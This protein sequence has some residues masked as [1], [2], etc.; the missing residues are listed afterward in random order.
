MRQWRIGK[1][2]F[3]ADQRC[4]RAG[5][6]SVL[7]E[8][9]ASS[10]L[11]Y[12]CQNPGR[13]I[14][15]DELIKTVWNNQIVTENSIN[16]VVVLLR[17]ALQDN[18]KPHQYLVTVP[19]VGYRLI[20][21]VHPITNESGHHS[22]KDL[23]Y[24]TPR[25]AI[26]ALFVLAVTLSIV[27]SI[28]SDT[29]TNSTADRIAITP[30]S[31]LSVAQSNGVMSPDGQLLLY[32]AS[33]DTHSR[34]FL[35]DDQAQNPRPISPATGDADF[36]QWANDGSFALY[37]FFTE[38]R[39]EIHRVVRTTDGF[40]PPETIYNCYLGS[41]TELSLS[42]DNATMYFVER[43]LPVAP[44][45]AFA[46][47]LA[48]G[49][50]Q[51][52]SQPVARGYGN[53]HLDVHP[54]SGR[55]LLLGDRSPG[56]TS[57]FELDPKA[58]SFE[59]LLAMDYSV[60]SGIWSHREGYMVHPSRHPS[61]EL[62]ETSLGTGE[63]S[64]LISDSRR[65][66][67][68]R[69]IVSE[70]KDQEDYL[71]TSYLYNRDIEMPGEKTALLN[72]GAMDY[73]P[74]LSSNGNLLAFVS[75]RIGR[76]QI[77]IVD[78]NTGALEAIDPPEAGRRFHELAWSPDDEQLV[79]STNV[80]LMVFNMNARS[81]THDVSFELPLYGVSWYDNKTLAFSHF[82]TGKWR[83]FRYGLDTGQ[84]SM[85]DP[86]WA[87]SVSNAQQTLFFDQ[88]FEV[89]R[90]DVRLTALERCGPPLWRYQ[91]RVEL[92]GTDFYCHAGD[93][94]ND[95]LKFD[96]SLRSTRMK[97]VVSRYEFFSVSNG[98]VAKTR[99]VSTFSDIMRTQRGT[100]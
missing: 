72:S 82:D 99:V 92:D 19:K 83:A 94:D 52:L 67:S 84:A 93:A 91:L 98:E 11:A 46:L 28:T 16:R 63:T 53:H 49:T 59:L 24:F 12:L 39:C 69:R 25:L 17:K 79:A 2:E 70:D 86:R 37:Q 58:R 36:A 20:A 65:V 100:G 42:L 27:F 35:L 97:D 61:Y 60:E 44:Y 9:K 31:R 3:D 75:K 29:E 48:T 41:F 95:V 71:F 76:S 38:E 40:G 21:S 90:D 68:P 57:V 87:L 51:R 8:P 4:L 1:V 96:A 89:Y 66:T 74:S 14:S 64:V 85:L 88:A 30:V 34:I 33:D 10:L 81:W 55:L 6:Q 43:E 23:E 22:P 18:E 26:V 80:G 5:K 50:K 7:L 54:Q 47:S 32:T 62:V 78:L 56:K 45:E 13:D 77:L 15:R 73:L